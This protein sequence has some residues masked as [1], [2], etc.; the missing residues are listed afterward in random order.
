[1]KNFVHD[2]FDLL[3]KRDFD[4]LKEQLSPDVVFYFPGT[5]PLQG[6]N[7]VAQLM[8]IIYRKY[9]DLTFTVED[10]IV[11]ENKIAVAWENSGTDTQGNPYNN[12]GVT[13]IKIDKD[14]VVYLSDYFKNTSFI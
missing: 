5:N 6:P 7:K 9:P 8:R 1:M 10:I 3:N 11:Q 13:I 4:S 12:Q 14:K 2:F